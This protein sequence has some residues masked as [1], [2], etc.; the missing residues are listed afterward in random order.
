[1]HNNFVLLE[2]TMDSLAL[3]LKYN[4]L[5]LVRRCLYFL[6][7]VVVITCTGCKDSDHR[8]Q[9]KGCR[10]DKDSIILMGNKLTNFF[11]VEFHCIHNM[12]IIG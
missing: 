1:M 3:H 12:M 6:A 5:L 4:V 11:D 2:T 9:Y 7:H 8:Q 10:Q